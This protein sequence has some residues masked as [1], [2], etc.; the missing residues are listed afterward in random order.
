MLGLRIVQFE[1]A[2][3]MFPDV[4]QW[5]VCGGGLSNIYETQKQS[6]GKT[7]LVLC[8]ENS[9]GPDMNPL[10]HGVLQDTS[11]MTSSTIQNEKKGKK[12]KTRVLYT[13]Q[14]LTYSHSYSEMMN[15]KSLN[16]RDVISDHKKVD[17]YEQSN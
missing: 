17:G 6:G 11:Q 15:I 4:F 13:N 7:V 14:R 12:Q 10:Y 1:Q 3:L 9:K 16:C 8:T 2:G 5:P